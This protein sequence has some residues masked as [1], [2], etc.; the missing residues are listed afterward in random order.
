MHRFMASIAF[1]AAARVAFAAV[2]DP[3]DDKR[4]LFLHAK[5]NLAEPAPGLAYRIEQDFVTEMRIKTSPF[6]WD[7]A[8]RQHHRRPSD[9]REQCQRR[10]TR[11]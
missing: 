6:V 2:R 9:G 4:H 7:T 8:E 11:P 3:E 1:V 10:G 5:N